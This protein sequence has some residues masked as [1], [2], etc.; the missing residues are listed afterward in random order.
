[1][2]SSHLAKG[3]RGNN[4]AIWSKNF[5]I[6]KAATCKEMLLRNF[7]SAYLQSQSFS[8]DR[9]FKSATFKSNSAVVFCVSAITFFSS[10]RLLQLHFRNSDSRCILMSVLIITAEAKDWHSSHSKF[11]KIFWALTV[12][13]WIVFGTEGSC[14]FFIDS[15]VL[16][17]HWK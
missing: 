16:Q 11:K 1:M 9:V 13:R 15:T 12:P 2:F 6:C 10:L 14:I 7:I 17:T 3:V 8:A 5:R 4:S